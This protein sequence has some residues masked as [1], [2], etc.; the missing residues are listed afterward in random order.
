MITPLLTAGEE[1][2]SSDSIRALESL[3]SRMSGSSPRSFLLVEDNPGDVVLLR[4]YLEEA[5]PATTLT[6]A[7]RLS[8]AVT[9]LAGGSFDAILLDLGL[10][11]G[12]GLGVVETVAAAAPQT[13][14]VVLTGMVDEEMA[15]LCLQAGAHDYLPKSELSAFLLKKTLVHACARK[16][17]EEM[18]QKLAHINRLTQLGRM[19]ANVAHEV[20]NPATVL[21]VNLQLAQEGLDCLSRDL[22]LA[23][24]SKAVPEYSAMRTRIADIEE[25]VKTSLDGLHLI[26]AVVDEMRTYS[27]RSERGGICDVNATCERAL[28]FI[29]GRSQNVA[30]VR[31]VFEPVGNLQIDAQRLIQ[32]LINLLQNALQAFATPIPM[33]NEIMVCTLRAD[34]SLIISVTDNGPGI[35]HSEVGRIFD[36]FY[37]TK[38]PE[39]G[40]GLGLA[41]SREMVEEMGGTLTCTSAPGQGATFSLRFPLSLVDDPPFGKRARGSA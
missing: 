22:Y 30:Q 5:F 37:S 9:T 3:S 7:R 27:R 40:T 19:A 8:E 34:Q 41:L 13:P 28:R 36:A 23:E 24:Y 35:P 1:K 39:E 6:C 10:P 20:N 14:V 26:V 18:R 2:I 16:S 4:N 33:M 15:K 38:P 31:T 17:G 29:K 12:S 21:M 32:V 11:D 25:S